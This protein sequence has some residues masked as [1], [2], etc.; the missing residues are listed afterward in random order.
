MFRLRVRQ[1][2][3]RELKGDLEKIQKGT[4]YVSRSVNLKLDHK[5]RSCILYLAITQKAL[6][7]GMY[8]DYL[9]NQ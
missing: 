2:F 9:M 7:L 5:S 3:G 6:Q 1:V 8:V 4:A